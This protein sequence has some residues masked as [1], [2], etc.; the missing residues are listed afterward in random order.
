MRDPAR[1]QQ[2]ILDLERRHRAERAVRFGRM[3]RWLRPLPRRSNLASYPVVKW[4]ADTARKRPYLW[5]FKNPGL[6]RAVYT[7]AVIA[8]LPVY[9]LQLLVAFWAAVLLRANLAV[10]CGIQLITNP[11]TAGPVY[12]LCYRIG[13]WIIHTF[14]IGVG[15]GATGTRFNALV[16]GGVVVGLAVGFL[17]DLLF[18]FAGWEAQR[19]RERHR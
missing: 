19:L 4:F 8:F 3:R 13:M 6:R 18:R 1:Q 11:F 10:T 7:G 12:Y 9:G 5:S 15:R 17:L 14:E 2:E 16:L